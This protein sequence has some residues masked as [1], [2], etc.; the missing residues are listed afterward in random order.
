[1]CCDTN[2]TAGS[3]HT[4]HL[5]LRQKRDPFIFRYE[6]AVD[7][8]RR[9]WTHEGVRG[10]YK[11]LGTSFIRVMPATMCTFVVYEHVSDAVRKMLL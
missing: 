3:T 10:F 8:M 5:S 2:A 7:V 11:G 1:M 4:V 6:G 9:I